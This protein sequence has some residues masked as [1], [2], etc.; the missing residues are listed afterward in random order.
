MVPVSEQFWRALG[1]TAAV[2]VDMYG[3]HGRQEKFQGHPFRVWSKAWE[4]EDEAQHILNVREHLDRRPGLSDHTI[5]MSSHNEE[6]ESELRCRHSLFEVDDHHEG[7]NGLL[8]II[9]YPVPESEESQRQATQNA[10]AFALDTG[11]AVANPQE[12]IELYHHLTNS[13]FFANKQDT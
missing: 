4:D 6:G 9:E 11:A 2:L 5:L 1:A 8:A 10:I 7:A 13:V 3:S 12:V